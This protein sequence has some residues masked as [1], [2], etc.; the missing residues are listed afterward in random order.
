M[1][2][3]TLQSYL[4][5]GVDGKLQLGLFPI[6][7]RQ[8]LHQ[9]GRESRPGSTS[10]T[11]KDEESLQASTLVSQLTDPVQDKIDYLLPDGVVTSSI[12]VGSI[13]FSGNKLFGVE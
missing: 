13:F 5:S 3:Q 2:T 4:W 7:N 9:K 1:I 8:P 11:M 6:I 10:E 12:V